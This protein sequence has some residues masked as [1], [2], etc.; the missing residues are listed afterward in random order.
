MK[1]IDSF[2][3]DHDVLYP[4]LYISRIDDPI[5]TYDIRTRRPN[6]GDYMSNAA[7]HS[8]EHLFATYVRNSVH[9]DQIIYFG[10]MGCWLRRRCRKKM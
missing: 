1:K 4:G 7:M 3:I 6:F 10:P 5:V 8:I 2:K 9:G